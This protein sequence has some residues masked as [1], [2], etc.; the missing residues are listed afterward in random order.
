MSETAHRIPPPDGRR[1]PLKAN[2]FQRM[3]DASCQLLALFPY[4]DAGAVVPCGAI[5]T[6]EPDDGEF[7]H[8]FHWNTVEELTV[9]YGASGA[10]LQTGQIFANQSLHGVNSFLRDP[11]DP[12]SYAVMTITQ[13]QSDDERQHEAII[14]RCK[15]C[16]EE[17]V[18]FDYES[19]PRGVEGHDPAQWG[20]SA[21]DE[22]PVFSTIWGSA[23]AAAR[24]NDES[25]RTCGNCGQVND[26]FPEPKWGW[27]RWVDQTRTANRS[28]AAL[29]AAIEA[30]GDAKKAVRA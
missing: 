15:K 7:G 25:V 11:K 10:M 21:D 4:H 8:F 9:V 24:L 13:R 22:Y 1:E 26:E 3:A 14:F 27:Q 2:V 28:E 20:G 29:R 5:F 18:R 17:L 30:L 6:G 23:E 12:G 19:T 16:H